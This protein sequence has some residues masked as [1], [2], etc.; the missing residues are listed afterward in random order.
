MDSVVKGTSSS[1][2]NSHNVAF[3]SFSSTNNATR[4]IN[5]IHGVNTA[6]TQGAAR[7]IVNN[8]G[9]FELMLGAWTLPTKKELGLTSPRWSVIN[10][11]YSTTRRPFNKITTA[12]NSNFTK[13]VNTVKGTKVNTARP[14]AVLSAVKG[15]KGNAVLRL[16]QP[17]NTH[18]SLTMLGLETKA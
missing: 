9:K 11:A 14:K 15:N 3:L 7:L 6:S 10:N 18:L 12:N 13:K 8:C 5:T 16:P 17:N 2:T 4:A 1:S